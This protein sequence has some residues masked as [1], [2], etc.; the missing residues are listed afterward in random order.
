MIFAAAGFFNIDIHTWTRAVGHH[1]NLKA[2]E[3][4]IVL[5]QSSFSTLD[6]SKSKPQIHLSWSG[7]LGSNG[8][9]RF[10]ES[11]QYK[12]NKQSLAMNSFK[13]DFDLRFLKSSVIVPPRRAERQP[14]LPLAPALSPFSPSLTP[15]QPQLLPPPVAEVSTIRLKGV[16]GFSHV[17]KP[18]FQRVMIQT[19]KKINGA[20][21]DLSDHISSNTV[22]LDNAI[23]AFLFLPSICLNSAGKPCQAKTISNI[24]DRI[25]ASPCVVVA[26]LEE[27][28]LF[29]K[30]L[31][32]PSAAGS[33]GRKALSNPTYQIPANILTKI[34]EF[35][36]IGRVGKAAE[37]L[38]SSYTASTPAMINSNG[39]IIKEIHEKFNLL[40]PIGPPLHSSCPSDDLID[41]TP[42]VISNDILAATIAELPLK[43]CNGLSSWTNDLLKYLCKPNRVSSEGIYVEDNLCKDIMDELLLLLNSLSQGKGGDAKLWINSFFF[44][45]LKSD[46]NLRPIAVDDIFIRLLGRCVSKSRSHVI[47][48][49]LLFKIF[50]VC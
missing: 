4:K 41:S 45:I 6:S 12:F 50:L 17:I 27:R 34:S 32:T 48:I 25:L 21:F 29:F 39:S 44:F 28:E 19:L 33:S 26:L 36:K 49:Q 9:Y 37:I 11:Y 43:S 3:S 2:P 38:M 42:H 10:L 24:L 16:T 7:G 14:V 40:H 1:S 31:K 5:H 15:S 20:I 30:S 18:L 23:A 13:G 46:N 35:I 47:R 8:H 22:W